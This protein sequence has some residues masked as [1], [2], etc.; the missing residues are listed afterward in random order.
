MG[1]VE[2]LHTK[3]ISPDKVQISFDY[4]LVVMNGTIGTGSASL[5]VE[6]IKRNSFDYWAISDIAL[7]DPGDTGIMIGAKKS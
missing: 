2:Q 1:K 5:M 3:V 6:K 4:P 7:K